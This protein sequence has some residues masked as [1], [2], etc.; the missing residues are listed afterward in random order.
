MAD[1]WYYQQQGERRG[2]VPL[3]ELR[4]LV[5]TGKI[6]ADTLV[7][8]Q[9][10]TGWV[11]LT[12][13]S[14]GPAGEIQEPVPPPLP[15]PPTPRRPSVRSK[16]ARSNRVPL[17]AAL[18]M[19]AIFLAAGLG[20]VA[21]SLFDVRR[22]EVAAVNNNDTKDIVAA[23]KTVEFL[24]KQPSRET[25]PSVVPSLPSTTVA[26][27][28]VSLEPAVV[29]DSDDP[30]ADLVPLQVKPVVKPPT[31][32][33]IE[34]PVVPTVVVPEA[35]VVEPS[36][37]EP[38]T[39]APTATA[40][41]TS[42]PKTTTPASQTTAEQTTPSLFQELD[43]HRMPKLGMLGTV[44][45]QDLRY[46][47][48]SELK[49]AEPDAEGTLSVE[50][51]V[52][53]T[54]LVKSDELS[55][56]MFESSL[57]ALKGWQFSYKLNSRRM[58]TEWKAAPPDGRKAAVVDLKGGKGFLVTSVMDDDGWKELA[59]HTFFAPAPG[60]NSQGWRRPMQH[61]FGP[62]GSWYGETVFTPQKKREGIQ[63]FGF[64]HKMEYRPAEKDL[65][66]L[67][68]KIERAM[69]KP[70]AAG[71]TIEYDTQLKRV[72]SAQE[73]FLV[74]G[75]LAVSMLGQSVEVEVEEQQVISLRIHDQ[76]PWTK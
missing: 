47:M 6:A 16:P 38:T 12:S 67:P 13:L 15:P 53:E 54:R 19:V 73:G 20:F 49:A 51:V 9:G 56:A 22:H 4:R 31:V 37:P 25:K 46:Q 3:A 48:L 35:P 61:N 24:V 43:I 42:A 5:E 76:N 27:K 2:P 68:F 65:G 28:E 58:I 74:R 14:T 7:W 10:M 41:P 62:L 52:L 8:R 55:R 63:Q 70:E 26:R 1:V 57:A 71:G 60:S 39:S 36:S 17:I 66:E 59:Q 32:V 69:L 44:T 34:T 40:P 75:G 11:P 45:V 30:A 50:Q 29:A 72:R 23:D 18:A 64:V 21:R 33:E